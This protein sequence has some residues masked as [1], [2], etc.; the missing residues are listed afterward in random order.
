MVYVV[1]DLNGCLDDWKK[2]IAKIDLRSKDMLFL[3]GDVIGGSGEPIKLLFDLMTRTNVFPVMGYKEFRFSECMSKLLPDATMENFMTGLDEY[4]MDTLAKFMNSGGRTV[5]EQYMALSEEDRQSVLEYLEEFSLYEELN[6]KNRKFVLTHSGLAGFDKDK[7]PGDYE[8][9]DYL[10]SRHEPGEK[11]YSDRILVFGHTPTFEFGD[12]YA[13][14]IIKTDCFI[15]VDCGA[16]YRDRGGRLGCVR[17][18]D[19]EEFYV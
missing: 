16:V 17:L 5:F 6:V 7:E 4:T 19:L 14:R 8:L 3:T 1:G 13:G 18:E 12:K 10:L 9:F 15:N 11:L 2:L